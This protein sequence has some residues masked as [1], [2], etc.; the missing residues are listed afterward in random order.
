MT[1]LNWE[2]QNRSEIAKEKRRESQ[3]TKILKAYQNGA[4]R[5]RERVIKLLEPLAKHDEL[6]YDEGK[7]T[8]YFDDC[9]ASDYQYAIELI[10]GEQ[11]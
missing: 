9:H 2:K 8:C 5:E 1:R 3:R 6:C 7:I 10:K 11:K 4:K